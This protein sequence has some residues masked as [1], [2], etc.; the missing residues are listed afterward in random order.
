MVN[1]NQN[2]KKVPLKDVNAGWRDK[3]AKMR[4][5]RGPGPGRVNSINCEKYDNLI[6]LNYI[7]LHY[8]LEGCVAGTGCQR[9]EGCVAGPISSLLRQLRLLACSE[10]ARCRLSL[11]RRDEE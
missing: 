5:S 2:S 7:S 10:S 4:A 8:L 3:P 1:Q 6:S 11:G 9:P